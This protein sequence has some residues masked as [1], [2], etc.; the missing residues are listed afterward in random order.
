MNKIYNLSIDI[1]ESENLYNEQPALAKQL[2][3]R[4]QNILESKAT[5][6]HQ[7]EH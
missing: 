7:E 3:E 6:N 4:L 2:R 1:S 5:V